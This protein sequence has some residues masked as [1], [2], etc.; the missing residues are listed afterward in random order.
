M[1]QLKVFPGGRERDDTDT[2]SF[3]SLIFLF[4]F[5]PLSLSVG[6]EGWDVCLLSARGSDNDTVQVREKLWK[7]ETHR[8]RKRVRRPRDGKIKM[9][10]KERERNVRE[11]LLWY[12]SLEALLNAGCGRSLPRVRGY[13]SCMVWLYFPLFLH[14][15]LTSSRYEFLVAT[16]HQ[17]SILVS[18]C[19]SLDCTYFKCLNCKGLYIFT[20]SA[21]RKLQRTTFLK[22]SMSC[23]NELHNN[24]PLHI[25]KAV[26]AKAS[27]DSSMEQQW[28]SWSFQCTRQSL[29][30]VL[31][32]VK[33]QVKRSSTI[34]GCSL[35]PLICA[36]ETNV[37]E[38]VN[39]RREWITAAR[40]KLRAAV[41][42]FLF[43]SF[44]TWKG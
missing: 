5:F 23:L 36:K 27:N 2:Q 8:T 40:C 29:T 10:K 31:G 17:S 43:F 13:H 16:D 30:T 37:V 4:L 21:L 18:P 28:Q 44:G 3:L 1:F 14:L 32:D 33:P 25:S 19:I 20:I 41:R 9:H 39:G 35:F 26:Y 7:R 6:A 24:Y 22:W 42:L 11:G 15:P 12:W 38:M 34:P